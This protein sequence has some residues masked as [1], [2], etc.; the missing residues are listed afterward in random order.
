[1][2]AD[3]VLN[4]LRL[5]RTI[6]HLRPVQIYGRLWFLLVRPR[7]DLSPVP[8]LRAQ[9]GSWQHPARRVPSLTEPG[10]FRFLNEDGT[11]ADHGWDDPTKAKLWRYN[12]HY[13]D[14][15]NAESSA[16]RDSWHNELI[17]NWIAANSPGRGTGWEPYPTSLRIV[18]WVK[19]A[20]A[21]NTLDYAAQHS[22]AIQTR[23]LMRRLE[24]HLLG[25]H[26]F[27][28]A[29]ALVFAGLWFDGPEA[30]GWLATG[31]RILAREIPEQIL[32]DGGH[33]ELSPMYHAL[34]LEDM[35]DLVNI[36]RAYGRKDMADRWDEQ[37]P[38]MLRW[39]LAMTHPDGE[40]AFFNDTAFGIAPSVDQLMAYA[41]RLGNPA[42]LPLPDLLHLPASGYVRL[43]RGSAVLIADL[44][45]IGPDYLPSHSHADTLSF[46]LS[47]HGRRVI[48]NS[49]IS[50]YG[51]GTERLRQRGTAAHSTVVI[52]GKDSSEVWSGFRVGRRARP[53]D[54]EL[55]DD[56]G[57]LRVTGAHDG[58]SHL[59]DGPVH[60]RTWELSDDGLVVCDQIEGGTKHQ[61][62]ARFFLHPSLKLVE[63]KPLDYKIIDG[64]GA[65]L[66]AINSRDAHFCTE[67]S[68]WYPKFGCAMANTSLRATSI[69]I[70]DPSSQIVQMIWR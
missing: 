53:F 4:L 44:A 41:A 23:W 58:Y 46:E 39:L 59:P 51:L 20:L 21:G 38:L 60:R 68:F 30:A 67:P 54:I 61:V 49:G 40:L 5:W 26:L 50:V 29:K 62:E 31:M 9:S 6:R 48:V 55:C 7:P 24:W 22:L 12:Q 43:T 66:A 8:Q 69:S 64:G 70:D 28:N 32:S 34:A 16:A 10:S 52:D 36:A 3:R 1:M 33:F 65:I 18:N 42:P 47:L 57:R 11:L 27:A 13:F 2:T 15:L 63:E 25:N 45:R 37:V 56:G 14:D 17:T 35:L 19:W